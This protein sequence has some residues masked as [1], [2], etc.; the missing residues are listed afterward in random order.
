MKTVTQFPGRTIYTIEAAADLLGLSARTVAGYCRDG[1][2]KANKRAGRWYIL[3]G[4][5]VA[6]VVGG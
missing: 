5:L 4:D 1:S 2:M 6:W 3:A